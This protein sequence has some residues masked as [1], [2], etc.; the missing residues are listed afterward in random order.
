MKEQTRTRERERIEVIF[1]GY[2]T[3]GKRYIHACARRGIPECARKSATNRFSK[4]SPPQVRCNSTIPVQLPTVLGDFA[5]F[6]PSPFFLSRLENSM[7]SLEHD[8]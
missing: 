6:F 2:V 1:I 8:A 3:A 4:L 7:V 5:I